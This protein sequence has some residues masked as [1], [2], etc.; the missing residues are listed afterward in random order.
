MAVVYKY[1]FK[2]KKPLQAK[3]QINGERSDASI[4][5]PNRKEKEMHG[6]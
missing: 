2:H 3:K 5:R 1:R 6:L 4:S